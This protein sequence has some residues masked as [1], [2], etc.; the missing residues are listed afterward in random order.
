L[1]NALELLSTYLVGLRQGMERWFDDM[2]M[3]QPTRDEDAE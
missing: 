1:Q 3:A 2:D